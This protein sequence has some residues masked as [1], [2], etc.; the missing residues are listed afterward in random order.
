[1]EILSGIEKKMRNLLTGLNL[2]FT[3]LI[4]LVWASEIFMNIYSGRGQNSHPHISQAIVETLGILIIAVFVQLVFR[5]WF[6]FFHTLLE[7]NRETQKELEGSNSRFRIMFDNAPAFAC[8]ISQNRTFIYVNR[9]YQEH[10]GY[11]QTELESM[12]IEDLSSAE[13]REEIISNYHSLFL[14][15]QPKSIHVKQILRKDGEPLWIRETSTLIPGNAYRVPEAVVLGEL[16]THRQDLESKLRESE[17]LR[18]LGLLA[19]GIA[20]EFN[21]QLMGILG[22]TSLLKDGISDPRQTE[23]LDYIGSSARQASEVTRNLLA[24]AKKGSGLSLPVNVHSLIQETMPL[25]EPEMGDSID[26]QVQLNGKSSLIKGDP[27]QIQNVILNLGMNARDAMPEGGI[28][29]LT[30]GNLKIPDDLPD[31][32][33]RPLPP[34]NYL[35]LIFEDTGTGMN[36]QTMSRIFEPFFTTKATFGGSGMGLAA[37]FGTV[38]SHGGTITVDSRPGEGSRFTLYLPL[39]E[40]ESPEPETENPQLIFQHQDPK[41]NILLIDDEPEVLECTR[42]MLIQQGCAVTAFSF[43]EEGIRFYRNH[44]EKVDLILLDLIM[45]GIDGASAFRELREHNPEAVIYLFSGYRD[46]E[47]IRGLLSQGALGIINKPVECQ[48]LSGHV[49]R[50]LARNL[51]VREKKDKTSE[52]DS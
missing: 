33:L 4:L 40:S 45:P 52:E 1:M 31:E 13:F 34:G 11:T 39:I 43:P 2:L 20:H 37:V 46:T 15:H 5:F 30:T 10:L 44:A 42:E 19:G 36:Q 23:Y 29:K 22:F 50:G 25:L 28:L 6:G 35:Q 41:P 49:A 47:T 21:N 7:E 16:I 26:R 27:G 32:R 18:A 12:K 38:E 24:F 51:E 9:Y 48:E 3:L 8:L 17:K 14:R